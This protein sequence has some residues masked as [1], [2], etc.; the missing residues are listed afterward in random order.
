MTKQRRKTSKTSPK[1]Q[2]ATS[3]R[4]IIALA[5]ELIEARASYRRAWLDGYSGTWQLYRRLPRLKRKL[6]IELN[7]LRRVCAA[8]GMPKNDDTIASVVEAKE[9]LVRNLGWCF[10]RNAEWPSIEDHRNLRD[11]LWWLSLEVDV[12]LLRQEREA[13]VVLP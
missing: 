3:S 10:P 4:R 5:M 11:A 13:A 12:L 7:R 9:A 2:I 8:L 6:T 1:R